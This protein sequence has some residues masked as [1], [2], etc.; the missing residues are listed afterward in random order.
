ML[1]HSLYCTAQPINM[2]QHVTH[3]YDKYRYKL[4]VYGEA[5]YAE[6][7]EAGHFDGAPVL[8]IPGN[9]GSCNQGVCM[10]CTCVSACRVRAVRSLG[11]VSF[12]KTA[13]LAK[14]AS[15]DDRVPHFNYFAV[16]FDEEFCALS[17]VTLERQ[18]QFT[19]LAIE[20]IFHIYRKL[21]AVKL[22]SKITGKSPTLVGN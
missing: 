14:H 6:R 12:M 17:G 10:V 8:F 19:R 21:D 11:S 9:A 15:S 18:A 13:A 2:P 5:A 7:L 22:S 16:D 4:I 20:H 3:Q 1:A